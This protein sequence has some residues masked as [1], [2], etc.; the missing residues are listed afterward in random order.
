LKKVFLEIFLTMNRI[1]KFGEREEK[2]DQ[3]LPSGFSTHRY[4][5]LRCSRE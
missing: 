1:F 4:K 2:Y 3:V 5:S